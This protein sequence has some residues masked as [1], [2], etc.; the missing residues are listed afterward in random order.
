MALDPKYYFNKGKPIFKR[1]FKKLEEL[2]SAQGGDVADITALEKV[3]GDA[4]S[5]LVKDVA[6]LQNGKAD[7]A[8]THSLT[9]VSD[10]TAVE[11]TVTYSDD[12][13]ETILLVKQVVSGD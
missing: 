9:D 12:S 1:W 13:T 10:L 2:D 11:A 5:G 7:A 6:D 8:H 4:D 3:V